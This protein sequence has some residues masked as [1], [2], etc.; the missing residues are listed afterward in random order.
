MEKMTKQRFYLCLG[1]VAAALIS[2]LL[3]SRIWTSVDFHSGSISYINEKIGNVMGL[4][5]A[6][7]AASAA[8]S[9][10]PGDAG[11]PVAN[12]LASF[13]S[14]FMLIM[15][16]L[17]LEKYLLIMTGYIAFYGLIPLSCFFGIL[18]VFKHKDQY[19]QIT[20]KLIVFAALI[21][22]TIPVSIQ[23]SKAIDDIYQYSTENVVEQANDI[24]VEDVPQQEKAQN[25]LEG[26][27][28]SVQEGIDSVTMGLSDAVE[29][30]KMLVSNMIEAIAIMI[31]TS[32]VIPIVVFMILLWGSKSIMGIN[33]EVVDLNKLLNIKSK[34]N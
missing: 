33:Y 29:E 22:L 11:L 16:G 32:C 2:A 19:K 8:I 12:Q 4:T 9:L 10:I 27:I 5:A 14:E 7:T 1:L 6:S 25:W 17:Y 26:L 34:K 13:S 23:I 20:I 3:L 21:L 28:D 24:K 30:G 15:C 18:N 31:I